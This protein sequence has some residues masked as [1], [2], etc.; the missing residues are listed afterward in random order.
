MGGPAKLVFTSN[1]APGEVVDLSVN[2]TAPHDE[3]GSCLTQVAH[4]TANFT[5]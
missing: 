5:L 3:L 1:V 2:L 4:A